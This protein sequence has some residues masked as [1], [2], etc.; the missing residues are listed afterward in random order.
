MN[1]G[2]YKDPQWGFH[3]NYNFPPDWSEFI[4]LVTDVPS[5]VDRAALLFCGGDMIPQTRELLIES[6][7]QLDELTEQT[8]RIR[9][10]FYLAL[11]SPEGAILK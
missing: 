3:P 1:R 9:L 2:F 4:P 7:S 10:A 11:M 6:I 8:E 5:L